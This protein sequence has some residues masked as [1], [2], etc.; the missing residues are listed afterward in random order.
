MLYY[1]FIF[2]AYNSHIY[3]LFLCIFALNLTLIKYKCIRV[4]L[5]YFSFDTD[6]K[7]VLKNSIYR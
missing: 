3:S 5:E 4:V 2:N 6:F 7:N 1:I